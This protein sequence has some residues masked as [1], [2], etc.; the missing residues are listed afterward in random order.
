MDRLKQHLR[1]GL[2]RLF[3]GTASSCMHTVG[4]QSWAGCH[5]CMCGAAQH[6]QQQGVEPQDQGIGTEDI[7][8]AIIFHEVLGA[9]MAV[10]FW[11]VWSCRVRPKNGMETQANK[12][13]STIYRMRK[14]R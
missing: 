7:P 13:R 2:G 1:V 5:V 6:L 8:T 11:C 3:G 10:G 9:A 14:C 4:H 12:K